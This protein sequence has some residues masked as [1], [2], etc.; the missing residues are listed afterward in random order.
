MNTVTT[1]TPPPRR[2]AGPR[3]PGP[4][5]VLALVVAI[6]AL[7][8]FVTH[9]W[10]DSQVTESE[11]APETPAVTVAPTNVLTSPLFTMRRMSTT[12]S[13]ALS[14]DGFRAEVEGFMPSLNDR[15]CVAVSVD[16]EPVAS[17]NADLAV[18]P[19]STQKLLVAAARPAF[20]MRSNTSCCGRSGPYS[21]AQ[22][23][24]ARSTSA[25]VGLAAA[26]DILK[27]N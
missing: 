26:S 8:L 15:S 16:G 17:R 20:A 21:S 13:R 2:S 23:W 4:L 10:A 7:L 12:V 11:P 3:G 19:A 9:R 27:A 1:P 24:S 14:I 25:G 6:P 18:I 22:R 5:I